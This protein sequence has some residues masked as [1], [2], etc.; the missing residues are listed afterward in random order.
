MKLLSTFCGAAA[1]IAMT[2]IAPSALAAPILGWSGEAA[3]TG[4]KTT[5]NTETT[6]LGV[7]L[8]LKRE[9][10]DFRHKFKGRFDYGKNKGNRNK[11]RLGLGYQV[12]RDVSERLFILGTADYFQDDFGAFEEGYYVGAGF[13]YKVLMN[14]PTQWDLSGGIG[15]R[16]QTPQNETTP[17]KEEVALQLRSDFDHALNDAVSIYNNTELLHSK[18]DTYIW[19]EIGLNAK[20]MGDLAARISYRID[21]HSTVPAGRKKTD[22]ITRIGVVYKMK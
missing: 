17:A 22:T 4:S 5:G 6:D 13:G 2:S 12:E 16:E 1:L 19:N 18:S 15:Y 10:G 3:V 7:N 21:N 14:D 11:Q 20:L 8:K 9:F